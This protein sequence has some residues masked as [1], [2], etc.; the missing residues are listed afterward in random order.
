MLEVI[1]PT[2]ESD[3]GVEVAPKET[4]SPQDSPTLA[5]SVEPIPAKV[6]EV[7]SAVTFEQSLEVGADKQQENAQLQEPVEMETSTTHEPEPTST[8]VKVELAATVPDVPSKGEDQQT[9]SPSMGIEASPANQAQPFEIVN[10]GSATEAEAKQAEQTAEIVAAAS[11]EDQRADDPAP[12]SDAELAAALQLLTPATGTTESSPS[13][14]TGVPSHPSEHLDEVA[15]SGPRWFA[16]TVALSAEE[17]SIS[18]EAEMFGTSFAAATSAA[19]SAGSAHPSAK[20]AGGESGMERGI[21]FSGIA[22]AVETRLAEA[23]LGASGLTWASERERSAE[24]AAAEAA[25]ALE[26]SLELLAAASVATPPTTHASQAVDDVERRMASERSEAGRSE[27]REVA[28]EEKSERENSVTFA[29][30]ISDGNKNEIESIAGRN[31]EVNQPHGEINPTTE[32]IGDSMEVEDENSMNKNGKTKSGKSNSHDIGT[33]PHAS[34]DLAEPTPQNGSAFEDS[35]KAMAAAASE[36]SSA[37][38]DASTIASIVDSV[39][40]DLRPRIVEEIARKL[41]KK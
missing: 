33:V 30:A 38:T 19:T 34:A 21:G 1:P 36:G 31:G 35:Q 27:S 17:T 26:A 18:L 12:P 24:N 3:A 4:E 15:P 41:A 20:P 32:P 23:G 14:G 8:A 11:V 7:A 16:E 9:S 13:N 40:A 37:S 28:A 10:A 6:E 22:A 2:N 29:D 39:M 25:S 5:M